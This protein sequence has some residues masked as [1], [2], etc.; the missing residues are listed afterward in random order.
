MIQP[1]KWTLACSVRLSLDAS[2]IFHAQER[3]K[4]RTN[5]YKAKDKGMEKKKTTDTEG[6]YPEYAFE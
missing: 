5:P 3:D 2:L 6:A 1:V 4:S